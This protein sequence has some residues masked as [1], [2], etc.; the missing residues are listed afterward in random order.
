MNRQNDPAAVFEAAAE[1]GGEPEADARADART[2]IRRHYVDRA[3]AR[4][5]HIQASILKDKEVL[6]FL[7]FVEETVENS[8]LETLRARVLQLHWFP[9][10]STMRMFEPHLDN[11]G[12]VQGEYLARH[13]P[14]LDDGRP[15]RIEDIAATG[16]AIDLYGR[17]FV[18]AD[19]NAYTRDWIRRHLGVDVGAPVSLPK[20]FRHPTADSTKPVA[21]PTV[22]S[23]D[24]GFESNAAL[25]FYSK[26]PDRRDR[27]VK[28]AG[29]VLRFEGLIDERPTGGDLVVVAVHFFLED[30]TVE[31]LAPPSINSGRGEGAQRIVARQRVPRPSEEDEARAIAEPPPEM[32]D[33]TEAA[34]AVASRA[35]PGTAPAE[36]TARRL[37]I[38]SPEQS[39]AEAR[40]AI[41]AKRTGA[42][43][44]FSGGSWSGT[45]VSPV[46]GQPLYGAGSVADAARL[47]AV[48][49]PV[50]HITPDLLHTGSW[51]TV[52]GRRVWL[53]RA[54][55]ATINWY[56]EH[57]GVDQAATAAR[58]PV[59]A[60]A[61]SRPRDPPVPPHTGVLA[62]GDEDETFHNA[63]RL[64]PTWRAKADFERFFSEEGKVLRFHARLEDPS[65]TD[66]PRE[67]VIAY[68]L[69]D[70][71]MSVNERPPS[72]GGYW[73]G[74]FLQRARYRNARAES[75]AFPADGAVTAEA[76][77]GD[78]AVS[79]EQRAA[80]LAAE[81]RL[82]GAGDLYGYGHGFGQGYPGGSLGRGE[83]VGAGCTGVPPA[84][85]VGMRQR[86]PF[87]P[88]PRFF[89]PADLHEGGRVEFDHA[90]GQVFVL[91]RA[92][93]FTR[94]YLARRAAERA[95]S[96]EAVEE[97]ITPA[98]ST[99]PSTTP[100][101]RIAGLLVG[102][103]ASVQRRLRALDRHAT[104]LVPAW[105][106]ARVLAEF[107]AVPP[108]VLDG[109][110]EAV[111]VDHRSDSS[112]RWQPLCAA[113]QSEQEDAAAR[114]LAA[115]GSGDVEAARVEQQLRAA[116]MTSRDHL[117]RCFRELGNDHEGAIT[118]REFR[119]LLRRHHLD[120]GMNMHD[121]TRVMRRFPMAADDPDVP[122]GAPEGSVSWRG[123]L[124]VLV[125]EPYGSATVS[126]SDLAELE[127]IARGVHRGLEAG[128]GQA[129]EFFSH[130]PRAAA[131]GRPRFAWSDG[132][133][134]GWAVP[135]PR[136]ATRAGRE[137]TTPH[138][139][140]L[141]ISEASEDVEPVPSRPLSSETSHD[142]AP[143]SAP[144]VL[145]RLRAFFRGR[146]WELKRTL[147]LYDPAGRGRVSRATMVAAFLSAGFELTMAEEDAMFGDMP[148]SASLDWAPLLERVLAN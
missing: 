111:L 18:I 81:R 44:R 47:R 27:F 51:V 85:G 39:A 133:G 89:E 19:A 97:P 40:A 98:G 3:T 75:E 91:A 92:D 71:T 107:G 123:F 132:L 122:A 100:L 127:N 93:S 116:L 15:L 79:L 96:V 134:D 105:A 66:A 110:I 146:Q 118:P 34:T 84:R 136:P 124:A 83:R 95:G 16:T 59:V 4:E 140:T 26:A 99:P 48:R 139:E 121:V 5:E 80:S 94:E 131:W 52:Y 56:W 112:V 117:R 17:T 28:A 106:T 73:C 49:A 29:K 6:K 41:A 62:I 126:S 113:L 87:V 114:G 70:G 77:A 65:P 42:R 32:L 102:C 12:L 25:G 36:T 55:Q 76:V 137:E 58:G 119:S 61:P 60:P 125:G 108:H 10:D 72:G 30:E 67:F 148:R 90:R 101:S 141:E 2:A 64:E 147:R 13:R 128:A 50:T 68:Y 14:H 23:F 45:Y 74:R 8:P 24:S 88:R 78:G 130:P 109:D 135:D 7:C 20:A 143:P 11:S 1:E 37:G 86:L 104:G 63:G 115:H 31:V 22:V 69:V 46:T 21:R 57:M 129:P 144:A 103:L 53:R 43:Y 33:A 142:S 35:R 9:S 120:L 145:D 138:D 82:G 38:V 54:D